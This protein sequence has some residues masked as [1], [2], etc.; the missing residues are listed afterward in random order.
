MAK[1][2]QKTIAGDDL[3]QESAP[4]QRLCRY[5]RQLQRLGITVGLSISLLGISQRVQAQNCDLNGGEFM[6]NTETSDSQARP[7]VA[8]DADGDFVV[9]WLSNDQDGDNSGVFG[10]IYQSNGTPVGNEFQIN[11]ETSSAQSSASVAMDANGNF[12]VVWESFDQDGDQD[13]IYGQLYQSDGTSVGSEFLVNSETENGQERPS[14]AMDT[15]GDFVVVWESS[16]QDGFNDGVYGQRYNSDGTV[17]GGEFQVNTYTTGSQEDASVAMDADGNFVVV[18]ESYQ[19]DGSSRG[20]YGQRYNSDGTENG[21][22]FRVNTFTFSVQDNPSVAMDADG[23]FVVVWESFRY[24]YTDDVYAQRYQKT[25]TPVG[26]E[27]RVNTEPMGFKGSADVKMDADGDFVVVWQR[28]NSYSSISEV[29][30]RRFQSDGTPLADEFQINTYTTDY[31]ES[32]SIGMDTDG[33]FVVAWNSDGQDNSFLGVYSQAYFGRCPELCDTDALVL[34]GSEDG[35]QSDITQAAITS[36]QSIEAG[37]V[38]VYQAATS[39]ELQVDFHAKG[40]SN[41]IAKI[42]DCV[43]ASNISSPSDPVVEERSMEYNKVESG[44]QVFPNP[45]SSITNIQFYLVQTSDV[46]LTITNMN[47]KIVYQ[48]KYLDLQMGWQQ[49][50]FDAS[51]LPDGMYFLHIIGA[52]QQV[53]KQLVVQR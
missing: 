24:G 27:F 36:T 26:V 33:D 32:P 38:V 5:E 1:R 11:T 16:R 34:S 14:V 19:Q 15:D 10:Q 12:V 41:F 30:G 52:K 44:V 6:V 37:A 46:V 50:Q 22:E 51:H 28:R 23:D 2:L 53:I 13:G 40:N 31:Q 48:Q 4:F 42:E 18:W 47:G 35:T 39:I 49:Q 20:I 43:A 3:R 45:L 21:G 9:V 17:N 7:D 25:G 8:M 29:Y